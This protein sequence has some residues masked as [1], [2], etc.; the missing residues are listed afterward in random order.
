MGG[1][2]NFVD[3]IARQLVALCEVTANKATNF[4]IANNTLY[5]S[6]L[7]VKTYAD[8]LVVGLLDD[9]GNYDASG[10]VFPSA[11]GS[12][13][14]GAILKGDLFYSS[15][16]GN[17]GGVAVTVGNTI[18]ALIDT[19][20]QTAGNWAIMDTAT[21]PAASHTTA[22]K[23]ELATAPEATPGTEHTRAATLAPIAAA[24]I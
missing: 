20:G 7:A 5:P 9:R 21:L 1:M 16:G 22:A 4:T 3:Y 18:R 8:A 12:G 11:G 13:T 14:A 6:V 19:L 2:R 15:V 10:N 17:L 24:G 23:V